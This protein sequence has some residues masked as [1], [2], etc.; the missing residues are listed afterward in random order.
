MI[1]FAEERQQKKLSDLRKKE[2]EETVKILS[3]KYNIPYLNL[4]TIPINMDALKLI[5]EPDAKTAELAVIQKI[6]KTLQI[7]TRNPEKTGVKAILKKLT[8]ERYE[9]QLFLV[10]STSLQKA[11]ETYKKIPKDDGVIGGEITI[12]PERLEEFQTKVS[13]TSD[14]QTLLE[15]VLHQRITDVL[16]IIIA[17]AVKLDASDIHIEPQ[18]DATLIRYRLDGTLYDLARIPAKH[19]KFLLSRVKLISDMKLNIHERGQDGRFTIR[20]GGVDVEVRTSTLPGPNGENMVLRILDPKNI[21]LSMKELGMQ[22]HI[23]EKMLKEIGKPNGMILTTGPTGSGKTTTLYAFLKQVN[24]PGVKIITIEDPIEYHLTGLEQTQV[25]PDKGYD[26]ANGLKSILR[27]DP[28]IILV[29][30]IRDLETAEIAMHAALT[31]HLV[32]STLHTN[33]AAGTIPRLIDL[34]VKPN[35]IAP[36]INLTMAQ[37]LLRKLCEGCKQSY[38]PTKEE[39]KEVKEAIAHVPEPIRPKIPKVL[40]RAKEGG[41][42]ACNS[43]GYKGRVG[44]FEIIGVDDTIEK[45]IISSP[46]EGDIKKAALAQGELMMR[47]DGV[48]KIVAGVTDF[49]ELNKAVGEE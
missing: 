31:G 13:K 40:Y 10:S 38:T 27:Q 26:F 29:G 20:K 2:E 4:A 43:I 30:E 32:F 39:E 15:S 34:G 48:L 3:G 35:I 49:A 25:E 12:S 5:A 44:I 16:E 46:S 45:L 1:Q 36:A 22:P 9:Y 33:N 18:E 19:Y 6:G 24:K 7:A 47:D 14:I 37:R 8:D 11:W 21:A 42:E 41:C 17:G 23:E 28:D